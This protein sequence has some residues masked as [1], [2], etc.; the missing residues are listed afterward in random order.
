MKAWMGLALLAL[1]IV[2]AA[3]LLLL[4]L[5]MPSLHSPG[6]L[7]TERLLATPEGNWR[8]EDAGEGDSALVLLHGFN[9]G[10]DQWDG[11]WAQLS[12]CGQRRIRVDLPGFAG[13]RFSS[14]DFSL[15]RQAERLLAFLDAR[16]LR[17]VTLA[18]SSMG[19]SLAAWFA[20]KHPERV[21]QVALFA[22]SGYPEALTYPGLFGMLVQPGRL[23]QTAT[24]I[25]R[26][27]LFSLLFPQSA[28]V[29]ALTVTASY[30]APWVEALPKVQAPTLLV[31]ARVDPVS[32]ASTAESVARL[33]P[34]STLLWLDASAGHSPP[35]TQPER[36]ASL[37]CRLAKGSSPAEVASP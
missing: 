17:R 35:N 7:P 14:D 6:P 29:Q 15:P 22:P 37:L 28:A 34:K 32:S 2:V 24:W 31:W 10:L 4:G 18:G 20:A 13:S 30:G 8:Y 36:V 3:P 5:V 21:H 23:N 27:K 12:A 33:I 1:A 26:T 11:V 9:Q 25:A 16:G 19:G